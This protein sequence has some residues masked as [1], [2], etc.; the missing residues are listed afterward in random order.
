M[1]DASEATAGH[2]N[3]PMSANVYRPPPMASGRACSVAGMVGAGRIA[4]RAAIRLTRAL[5]ALSV[6]G[7]AAR[8]AVA[9]QRLHSD[10]FALRGRGRCPQLAAG[11]TLLGPSSVVAAAGGLDPVV[12]AHAPPS[13]RRVI[14]AGHTAAGGVGLPGRGLSDGAVSALRQAAGSLQ[15][16]AQL[17]A[18][19]SEACPAAVLLRF[20]F[21][22]DTDVR[23][24]CVRNANCPDAVLALLLGRGNERT[25][26]L[27][28]SN[29]GCGPRVLSAVA[30]GWWPAEGAAAKRSTPEGNSIG[31]RSTRQVVASH[32]ALPAEMAERAFLRD[33]DLRVRL[34]ALEHPAQVARVIVSAAESPDA[35]LRVS[36]ARNPS[37]GVD[38]LRRLASDR[39][40]GVRETVAAFAA[41][42]AILDQL[43]RDPSVSVRRSAASN[44]ALPVD[45]LETL[46]G[47]ADM[48]IRGAVACNAS[49]PAHA[50]ETLAGDGDWPV[51]HAAATN[52][53][54]RA[55]VLDALAADPD[56]QVRKAVAQN[57]S[58]PY[59]ALRRLAADSDKAVAVV[60]STMFAFR[61]PDADIDADM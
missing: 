50:V 13:L 58:C 1:R 24:A 33:S 51:R 4:G 45:V 5:P 54:C 21:A 6:G 61:Y 35:L 48:R 56:D 55:S 9:A 18:V 11:A 47:D 17:Q 30:G 32:R 22:S 12:A 38:I 25:R 42:A 26:R 28:L 44:P 15:P 3:P 10:L 2:A 36:T 39:D 37:C 53:A 46:A 40:A 31:W 16:E 52:T 59:E 19:S 27:V 41:D 29:P 23:T 43:V 57:R 49:S 14:A 34:A 7:V 20:S 8:G 60:A